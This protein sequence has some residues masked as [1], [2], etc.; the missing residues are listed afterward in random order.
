MQNTASDER[1]KFD[2]A[3]HLRRRVDPGSGEFTETDGRYERVAVSIGPE[4]GTVGP[5]QVKEAA[6]EALRAW[7]ST[8]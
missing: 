2:S 1:L 6:K 8:C 7:A 3:R 5:D 4:H